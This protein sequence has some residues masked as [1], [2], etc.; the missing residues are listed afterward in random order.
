MTQINEE[1]LEAVKLL[2]ADSCLRC[3]KFL[4]CFLFLDW[5]NSDSLPPEWNYDDGKIIC[6]EFKDEDTC[7][8]FEDE[9]E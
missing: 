8:E 4:D 5:S 1:V 6:S 3:E 9:D 2:L 7:S